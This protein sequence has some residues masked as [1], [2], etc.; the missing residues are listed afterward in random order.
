MKPCPSYKGFFA[1]WLWR[2]ILWAFFCKG[3]IRKSRTMLYRL[4]R[5]AMLPCPGGGIIWPARQTLSGKLA[6]PRSGCRRSSRPHPERARER[7]VTACL[8]TTMPGQGIRRA[9]RLRVTVPVRSYN[10]AWQPCAPTASMSIWTWW[11]INGLAILRHLSSATPARMALRIR[12]GSLR[13]HRTSFPRFRATRIWAARLR[14]TFPSGGNWLLSTGCPTI[15]CLT[16]SSRR[17]TG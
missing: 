7:M 1:V 8:T 16:T 6:S 4:R 3:S 10:D 17:R 12:A 5:T 11:N 15:T 9:P 2:E 13:T 14:M